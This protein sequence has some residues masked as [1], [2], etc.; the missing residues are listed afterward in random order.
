LGYPDRRG[1]LRGL[2]EPAAEAAMLR[3]MRLH[4]TDEQLLSEHGLG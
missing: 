3:S 4:E 2:A 1:V